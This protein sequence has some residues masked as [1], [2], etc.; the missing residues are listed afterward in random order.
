MGADRSFDIDNAGIDW[1]GVGLKAEHYQAIL[2]TRPRMGFFEV[3]AE[4]Y[5]GAGGPP[6]RY[7]DAVRERYPLSIHGVGLSIGGDRPLDRTHLRHLTRLQRRFAPAL[8]SEHLAWS[9]HQRGFLNDL[10]PVP[11]TPEAL[12]RVATHV[13]QLQDALGRRMLLENPSTYVRFAESS[14]SETDFIAEIVRRTG[15][16]LLLDLNNA[17][18]SS[19][20]HGT[21]AGT[22]LSEFPLRHVEQ[23]HLAGH[24]TEQDDGGRPLLIDTHDRRVADPVWALYAEVVRKIGP[25]PTL[26]EWD[27]E[28]PAWEILETEAGVAARILEREVP[29]QRLRETMP[30]AKRATSVPDRPA[31]RV[32]EAT[33]DGHASLAQR[34]REFSMALLDPECPAPADLLGPDDQPSDRRFDVYRNNVVMGLISTLKDAFPVV[35]RLVGDEFFTAMAR[36][37]VAEAPP[38]HPIMADYGAEFPGF[39]ARFEPAGCLP[40][41]GDVAQIER[42]WIEAYHAP[43]ATPIEPARLARIP[44]EALSNV[45][46]TLHPSLR[47]VRSRFAALTIWAMHRDSAEQTRVDSIHDAQDILVVRPR[48]EVLVHSLPPGAAVFIDALLQG[49]AL[50]DAAGKA[51]QSHPDFALARCFGGLIETGSLVDY[52]VAGATSALAAT[53]VHSKRPTAHARHSRPHL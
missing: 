49:D 51:A 12:V 29:P 22:Y 13:D 5:M 7:L 14:Y 27:S 38:R 16:G 20:N 28:L 3:H 8:F 11:Y 31:K 19:I 33:I 53:H 2:R 30:F 39:V 9:T 48:A 41:L 6:H 46:F 47:L 21:D 25:V 36:I 23:I 4:N 37:H 24:A 42:A 44:A 10:L 17:Y 18:V 1:A 45:R 43:E 50:A 34:Q 26:I 40:Y 52:T 15:C 32:P 35:A